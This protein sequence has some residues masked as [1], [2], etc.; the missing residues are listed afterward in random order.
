MKFSLALLVAIVLIFDVEAASRGRGGRGRGGR[1]MRGA[2]RHSPLKR[3]LKVA[4]AI[5]GATA[6][7]AGAGIVAGHVTNAALSSQSAPVGEIPSE[8]ASPSEEAPQ[9]E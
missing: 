9:Q 8:E 1:S 5:A 6:F 2:A 3:G 7:A 4:G